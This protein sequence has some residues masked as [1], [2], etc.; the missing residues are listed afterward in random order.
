MTTLRFGSKGPEVELLQLGLNRAGLYGPAPDGTFGP[1]TQKAVLEFQR[2][3]GLAAD[4]IAGPRTWQALMPYLTGSRI[5]TVSG[6]DSLYRLAGRYGSSIRAIE[7]ANPSADPLNLQ[8]GSRLVIPLPFSVVPTN[9]SFTSQVLELCA[10]GLKARYPFIESGSIGSSV[11]GH[12]LLYFKIGAGKSEV[13]YNAAHH[14]NEWIT[15]PL[16][17]KYLENY[18]AAY[19]FGG[20]VSNKSAAALYGAASLFIVPMVNPDGVDLV[21]GLISEGSAAYDKALAMNEPPVAFPQGWKA[22]INGVDLNLQ[23][24]AGWEEAKRIKFAEGYTKPGPRDYVGSSPLSQPESASV[25]NFTLNHNFKLTLSYHTQGRVIYWKYDGYEPEGSYDIGRELSRL[26][27]Y[28]LEL[29]PPY[30]ANA[31]YKDWFI[32]HY[33]RPGYTIEAGIGAAPLPLSQF[34]EIYRENEGMLTYAQTAA[35]AV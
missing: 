33:N 30:S 15:S 16:L 1:A 21:T 6:G 17:M 32:Q 28:A 12:N 7:T 34:D 22:N 20:G 19:A 25:Y 10:A 9:I 11:L 18:A 35:D 8:I 27:G 13:F 4:G 26:S 24:P 3:S 23:Y 31:G 29:T 5:V 14:A 2:R